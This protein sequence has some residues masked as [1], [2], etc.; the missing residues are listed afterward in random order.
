MKYR[1]D[2]SPDAKKEFVNYL[3]GAEEFGAPTVTEL[4]DSLD[5]C[6]EALEDM[7][8][9]EIEKMKYI[10][11]KYKVMHIWKHYWMIF[12]IYEEEKAVKIEYIIDDRQ[13]YGTFIH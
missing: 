1:V 5:R 3:D 11:A 2:I 6:I 7:A 12:Q 13:N 8:H 9:E 4:L 10:P